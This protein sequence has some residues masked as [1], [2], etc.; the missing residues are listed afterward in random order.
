MST[1][2]IVKKSIYTAHQQHFLHLLRHLRL[3][4]GLTQ[5]ELASRLGTMQ[6]RITDY[7]RGIRRMDLMELR[8][9]C[10]ALGISIVD[11]V[12]RFDDLIANDG[13]Q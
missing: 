11:F 12:K 9:V 13:S 7:E 5:A 10:D 8:Q 4:A 3:E 2:N 1:L 6:S